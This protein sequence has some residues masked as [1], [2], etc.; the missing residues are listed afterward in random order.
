[1]KTLTPYGLRGTCRGLGDVYTLNTPGGKMTFDDAA[2]YEKYKQIV[3]QWDTAYGIAY[4]YN[5]HQPNWQDFVDGN[6]QLVIDAYRAAAAGSPQQNTSVMYNPTTG[7][8]QYSVLLPVD[9]NKYFKTTSKEEYELYNRYVA[10]FNECYAIATKYSFEKP[11]WAQFEAG[12]G[13][14]VLAQ[15]KTLEANKLTADAAEAARIAEAATA[16]ALAEAEA[17]ATAAE[18]RA[19]AAEVQAA[20]QTGDTEAQRT[21]EQALAKTMQKVQEAAATVQQAA[22]QDVTYTPPATT[23]TQTAPAEKKSNIPWGW[24]FGGLL[25]AGGVYYLSRGKKGGKKKKR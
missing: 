15:Y 6:G 5:L 16:R 17:A 8:I 22:A 19:A 20:K 23:N 4:T 25:L 21:A 11:T 1:M 3:A 10:L 13:E 18:Q 2:E 24:I 7:Q 9:G 14:N 12:Q